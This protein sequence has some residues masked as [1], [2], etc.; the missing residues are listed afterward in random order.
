MVVQLRKTSREALTLATQR[1]NHKLLGLIL[2]NTDKQ[3]RF[4][5]Y[6]YYHSARRPK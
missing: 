2:N 4:D 3:E 1:M 6:S 5:Y